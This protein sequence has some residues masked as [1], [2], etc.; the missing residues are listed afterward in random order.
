VKELAPKLSETQCRKVIGDW[1]TEEK[2]VER[3][4]NDPITRHKAKGLF[5]SSV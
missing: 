4:Y 5:L 1:I 3:N 2:L